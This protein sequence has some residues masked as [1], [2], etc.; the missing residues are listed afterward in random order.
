M[1]YRACKTASQPHSQAKGHSQDLQLT[2]G[3]IYLAAVT[4]ESVK[5]G[6]I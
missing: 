4:L 2:Y 1:I 3:P 5:L 6:L